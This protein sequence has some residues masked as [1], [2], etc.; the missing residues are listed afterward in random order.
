MLSTL[1]YHL[2]KEATLSLIARIF[3]ILG[4]TETNFFAVFPEYFDY[5]G[6]LK[7]FSIPTRYSNNDIGIYQVIYAAVGD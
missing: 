5:R 1:A 6:I 2:F 4:A 7:I 3:I